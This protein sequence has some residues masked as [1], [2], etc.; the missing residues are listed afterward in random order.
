MSVG[1]VDT[2]L[3]VNKVLDIYATF[4]TVWQHY[5]AGEA[6]KKKRTT[7]AAYQE[8]GKRP[9]GFKGYDDENDD[10]IVREGE[11]W[12]D[13]FYIIK[14]LGK[15]SFG[16]V[17]EAYDRASN[18]HVAIKII[19]NRKNFYNQAMVE[20]R[21]LQH[22]N[23]KDTDDSKCIVRMK[24]HFTFR[25]HLCIVYELLSINLYELLRRTSFRGVSLKLVRLFAKQIL[26][27]LKFLN[28]SD[29]Q[30]IH[31][32]LKPENILLKDLKSGSLKV[33]D[34][35]SSCFADEKA[36]TYIQSRFYR[37]PEIILGYPYTSAIDMWS[38]GCILVELISG[39]PLFSGQTEHDQICRICD[40][41]GIPPAYFLETCTQTKVG[42]MF[43]KVGESDYRLIPSK[44]FRPTQRTLSNILRTHLERHAATL[45]STK[46]S[47]N[48]GITDGGCFAELVRFTD[49]I[50]RML[51]FDPTK[52]MTPTD[53]LQHPFFKSVS[54][55]SS[56]TYLTQVGAEGRERASFS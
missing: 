4:L 51:Q 38:L 44:T 46:S 45:A 17:V 50:E 14:L 21:I 27:S 28:R 10:Y 41:L 23:T 18:A 29:I 8:N 5:Y 6:L 52:R 13:R 24:E 42:K 56:N 22:L 2:Y 49:L 15:G 26:T 33:I 9:K 19:K 35:G 31:C 7:T 3:A 11:L 48:K 12:N 43:I 53:A 20:I 16:Q 1:M 39:E 36:Y 55:H 25:N 54:D 32:D 40:V 37:S 34:F 30:I 47:P